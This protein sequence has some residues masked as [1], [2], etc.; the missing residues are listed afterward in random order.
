MSGSSIQESFRALAVEVIHLVERGRREGTLAPTEQ[1][2]F[3]WRLQGNLTY[4]EQGV[5]VPSARGE[6][7][8]RP[9]W[10][11]AVA[12]VAQVKALEAKEY[13]AVVAE[14]TRRK[15]VNVDQLL[16]QFVFRVARTVLESDSPPPS[17]AFDSIVERFLDDIAGIPFDGGGEVRLEG[18]S[19]EN[20][21]AHPFPGISLRRPKRED[22]EEEYPYFGPGARFDASIHGT[23]S[24]V[25]KVYGKCSS[26]LDAQ[27]K[28]EQFIVMLRLFKVMSAKYIS[29]RLIGN[30][31]IQPIGGTFTAGAREIVRERGVIGVNEESRLLRF[32]NVVGPIL[33]RMFYDVTGNA[34][35]YR[36]M[37]YER[38]N[39]AL[40]HP[41]S[42]EER[43]ANAIMSLEAILL[44]EHLELAYK[45]RFRAA[46]LLSN[47][48]ENASRVPDTLNDAYRAR[49]IFA[50]GARPSPKDKTRLESHYG[51]LDALVTKVLDLA[52]KVIL[53]SV[54]VTHSKNDI[55]AL[56]DDSLI[57]K[58]AEIQLQELVSR[59]AQVV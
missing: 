28:V 38:Y 4:N 18:I 34:S 27:M 13:Q 37:A 53:V 6:M 35:D 48:G 46:K 16:Q 41:G 54:L 2:Y 59:V 32:W 30:S 47:L 58:S 42:P 50:H 20:E 45:L 36:D 19:L 23:L 57:E 17:N 43:L 5:K 14:L 26:S 31:I 9:S 21:A 51:S 55:I 7:S 25:A 11:I 56:I 39:A 24:A 1:A 40:M 12:T 22:F 49:S 10:N 3:R 29:Y 52:R 33:P 15:L 44:N 8:V